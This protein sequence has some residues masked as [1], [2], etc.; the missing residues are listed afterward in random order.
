MK[1]WDVTWIESKNDPSPYGVGVKAELKCAWS[2]SHEAL[3]KFI[4]EI[5]QKNIDCGVHTSM[6]SYQYRDWHKS[7]LDTYLQVMLPGQVPNMIYKPM[8]VEDQTRAIDLLVECESEMFQSNWHT[9][10]ANLSQ[11]TL[12]QT[13]R[14]F[15]ER[16]K[17]K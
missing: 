14:Q 16:V 7:F 1:V 4:V 12:Y 10:S 9:R 8:S 13:L 2:H 3:E 6:V 5:S 17:V 11:I 15:I